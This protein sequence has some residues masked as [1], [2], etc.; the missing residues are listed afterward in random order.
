M[1]KVIKSPLRLSVFILCF[2]Y[3]TGI[4]FFSK[5]YQAESGEIA[6]VKKDVPDELSGRV[7]EIFNRSCT[8]AGCHSGTNPQMGLKLTEEAYFQTTVNRAS[9]EKPDLLRINPGKPDSSY[10]VM[11]IIDAENITGLQMPFGRDPLTESEISTIVDWIKNLSS[12]QKISETP[13]PKFPL[14]PFNGW[15][16]VNIPTSRTVDAGRWYFLIAH[17]FLP[18]VNNGYDAFYGLDGP[19]NIFL[20]FGYAFTDRFYVNLARSNVGDNVE[21]DVRYGL[22]DQYEGDNIPLAAGVQFSINWISEKRQGKDRFRPEVFK[23]SLQASVAHHIRDGLAVILVPGLL[24]NPDSET[25]SEDPLIT[26][27]MGGKIHVYKSI[28]LVGEWIPMV[29]GYILTQTFGNYNRF[30]TWAGGMEI[31]VGGHVFQIILTNSTGLTTD[32]YMR[33]GDLD[34][35]DGD[36]RLGFN[37]F[38]ILEF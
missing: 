26:I 29:S 19:A 25:A 4:P 22:K 15:K 13:S 32:Q 5:R 3:L 23:Y 18:N 24:I 12:D 38:R 1:K 8:G 30:D 21:L 33:G 27:G 11:K 16:V 2:L 36:M 31:A 20:N 7:V 28:S 14:L 34:L 35:R 37:I 10:L 9:V 6:S 17:R